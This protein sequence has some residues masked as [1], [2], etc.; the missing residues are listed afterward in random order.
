M[1]DSQQKLRVGMKLSDVE[2]ILGPPSSQLGGGSLLALV[3]SVSASPSATSSV[4]HRRYVV[5]RKQEGEYKLVFVGDELVDIYST[6]RAEV[7]PE[8]MSDASQVE[9][10]ASQ[11]SHA[12]LP[13]PPVTSTP[14]PPI[15]PRMTAPTGFSE[16]YK[17][18]F[19]HQPKYVQCLLWLLYGFIWIPLWYS[20]RRQDPDT[21]SEHLPP[22]GYT[23]ADTEF[24][25]EWRRF[26]GYGIDLTVGVGLGLAFVNSGALSPSEQREVGL[27]FIL[28]TAL[29]ST[30]LPE[31]LFAR[32]LGKLLTGTRVVNIHGEKPGLGRAFLRMLLRCIPFEPLSLRRG[33]MWHDTLSGTRVVQMSTS[34]QDTSLFR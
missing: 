1:T 31:A 8:G 24:A 12:A 33:A 10:D 7:A 15:S 3:G 13:P 4:S 14:P 18:K 28:A 25:S 16:W 19:G 26:V 34:R 30:M 6:P 29:G 32:S 27:I 20:A 5:W 17:Q 21:S 9:P 11:L 22:T 2:G 23:T